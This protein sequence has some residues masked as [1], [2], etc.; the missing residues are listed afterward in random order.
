MRLKQEIKKRR[1]SE[2]AFA[3]LSGVSHTWLRRILGGEHAGTKAR[4]KIRAALSVCTVCGHEMD[5]PSDDVLFAK[6][7]RGRKKS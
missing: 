2:T 3:E 4:A 5:V 7:G 1:I 6:A